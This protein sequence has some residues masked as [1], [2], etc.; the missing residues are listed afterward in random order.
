MLTLR[1]MCNS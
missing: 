1:A